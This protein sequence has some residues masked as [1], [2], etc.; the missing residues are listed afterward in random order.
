MIYIQMDSTTLA[1]KI[2]QR[3]TNSRFQKIHMIEIVNEKEI[4]VVYSNQEQSTG[5]EEYAV[6]EKDQGKQIPY[7]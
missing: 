7:F 6:D 5:V 3:G 1:E 2:G 4:G